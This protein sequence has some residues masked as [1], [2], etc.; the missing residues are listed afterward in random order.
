VPFKSSYANLGE[1]LESLNAIPSQDVV[2]VCYGG[3][4]A[5]SVET[6]TK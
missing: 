5:A 3:K 6:S 4:F 2:P 1:Y